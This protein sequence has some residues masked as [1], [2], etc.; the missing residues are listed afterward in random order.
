MVVDNSRGGIQALIG[1]QLHLLA[2][3]T[4][5]GGDLLAHGLAVHVEGVELVEV[6]GLLGHSE[7]Q[8]SLGEVD[9]LLVLGNEVGLTLEGD[10]SSELAV[11]LAD[12]DTLSCLTV[13]TLGGDGLSALADQ[14]H[15]LGDVVVA[16]DERLLAVAQACA[17]HV[18]Q[19]LDVIDGYSH[20]SVLIN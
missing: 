15:S 5:Q 16:L 17:G 20:N 13:F 14:F 1:T 7:V 8:D 18:A 2:G 12:S 11:G 9:K 10:D 4:A 19:F 6:S 3:D